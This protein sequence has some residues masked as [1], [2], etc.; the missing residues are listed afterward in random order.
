MF[1]SVSHSLCSVL[2]EG[3]TELLFLWAGRLF[4]WRD[5]TFWPEV[6][7]NQRL[8][9]DT[10]SWEYG[11]GVEGEREERFLARNG[12]KDNKEGWRM[13]GGGG[14]SKEMVITTAQNRQV[15]RVVKRGK[16]EVAF[17]PW[18]KLDNGCTRMREE[19]GNSRRGEK[20]RRKVVLSIVKATSFWVTT[21]ESVRE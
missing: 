14:L 6:Q 8:P 2:G 4:V 15:V 21:S 3:A 17:A 1:P 13:R 10:R 18:W 19:M 11:G 12:R 16:W 7:Q 9:R 5:G 20:V